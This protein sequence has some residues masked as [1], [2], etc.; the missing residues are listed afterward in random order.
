MD[1][2]VASAPQW[3][4]R[5][6]GHVLAGVLVVRDH[7]NIEAQIVLDGTPLYRSRHSTRAIAEEELAE[8][9]GQCARE[10]WIVGGH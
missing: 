7:L 4:L 2:H 6:E 5:S 10:G 8:L 1:Q 3:W 9:R